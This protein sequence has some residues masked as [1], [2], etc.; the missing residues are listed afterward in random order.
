MY[1]KGRNKEGN[2]IRV[3][4]PISGDKIIWD[5]AGGVKNLDWA[6]LHMSS[7]LIPREIKDVY[8]LSVGSKAEKIKRGEIE[9]ANELLAKFPSHDLQQ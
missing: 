1:R 3:T 7:S 2:I 9:L 4:D 5:P 8:S 6:L